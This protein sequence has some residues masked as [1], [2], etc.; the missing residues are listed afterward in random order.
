M[1]GNVVLISVSMDHPAQDQQA[2]RIQCS[3]DEPGLCVFG[4]ENMMSG[5]RVE[6]TESNAERFPVLALRSYVSLGR[7][8]GRSKNLELLAALVSQWGA[9][10]AKVTAHLEKMS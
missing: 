3:D 4:S 8:R 9:G 6:R 2:V 7:S 10:R 5:R 1:E